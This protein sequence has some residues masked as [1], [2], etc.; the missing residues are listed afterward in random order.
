MLTPGN[1]S[2]RWFQHAGRSCTALCLTNG[3]RVRFIDADGKV[4]NP[5]SG[6]ALFY[7]GHDAQ[8]FARVFGDIGVIVRPA[9]ELRDA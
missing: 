1:T 4:A 3:R 7:F 8:L 2:T 6:S 5:A 9:K